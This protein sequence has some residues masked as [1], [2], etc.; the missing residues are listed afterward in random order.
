[1]KYDKA[2]LLML[3]DSATIKALLRLYGLGYKSIAVRFGVTRPAIN[4][5]LRH[6]SFKDY[7]RQILLDL[8]FQLGMEATEL[9]LINKMINTTGRCKHETY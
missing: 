2:E 3:L 1:M 5:M 6:D 9:I 4:Y 7:Q 8:F